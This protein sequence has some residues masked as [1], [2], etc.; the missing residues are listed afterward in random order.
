MMRF[1]VLASGSKGNATFIEAESTRILIDAG[2]SGREIER[3]LTALGVEM[4]SLT[5]LL[6]THEHTDHT[7]ALGVLAKRHRL[8]VHANTATLRALGPQLLDPS[9][10]HPFTTG[11]SFQIGSL[12][13]HPFSVSHDAADPVGFVLD[14]GRCRIGQCTDTGVATRLIRHRL[15]RCEALIL[16]SNHD[17]RLL[18]DGPYPYPLKQRIS[19]VRG[20]LSNNEAAELCC[21]LL[22]DSLQHVV[23]AHLSETNN[24]PQKA[25]DAFQEAAARRALRLP[26]I[27]LGWQER[28][29]ELVSL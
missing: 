11:A 25:A 6:V 22:H 8:G 19:G 27:S 3:R 17:P 5:A 28:I 20:H 29:G 13:I 4:T 18:L 10:V 24:L 2:L 23:L 16:E 9:I 15:T 26:A 21:D 14:D 12:T 1:C 7:R